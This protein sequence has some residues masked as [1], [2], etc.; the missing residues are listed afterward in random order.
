MGLL[1]NKVCVVTGG[2]GSIGLASARRFID[3]G[4]R[5]M[6]VDL[7]QAQLDKAVAL[8]STPASDQVFGRAGDVADAAQVEASYEAVV[9]RWGKIDV[10][11]SN[12]GNAGRNARLE[13]YPEDIFDRTLTI[14]ARGAFLACKYGAPLMNDGGSIIITSS[15]AGVRGGNG[16]NMAY[17]T[18]KH[19][20]IGVMRVA[21]RALAGRGIRVNTIN[22]GPV[23][24]AFQTGIEVEMGQLIGINVTEQLNQTVPLK[25]HADASEIAGAVLYFASSLSTYTTG[26]VHMVDGGLMS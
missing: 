4:A 11:F 12:A 25:R 2:A 14:H 6:L 3:E 16:V 13:S 18:A 8:L 22:P 20:Q 19:A 10:L 23:D 7:D 9:A 1:Q 17:V 26:T 5:V 15:I 21:A 24:N